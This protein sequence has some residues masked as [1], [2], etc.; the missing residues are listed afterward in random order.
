M[1][2]FNLRTITT[3]YVFSWWQGSLQTIVKTSSNKCSNL[4]WSNQR[5]ADDIMWFLYKISRIILSLLA[6]VLILSC[7]QCSDWNDFNYSQWSKRN[8]F[9]YGTLDTSVVT[10]WGTL[11]IKPDWNRR[12]SRKTLFRS[13][14]SKRFYKSCS[15]IVGSYASLLLERA[16]L[17]LA[18]N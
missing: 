4:E 11:Q 13:Y 10:S 7:L 17:A 16:M 15:V 3:R 5:A 14:Y 2:T 8:S 6:A 18:Y 12:S 1:R 9:K